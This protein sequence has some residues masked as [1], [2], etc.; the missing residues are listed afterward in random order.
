MVVV[1]RAL[2]GVRSSAWSSM[3]GRRHAEVLMRFKASA[4][5]IAARVVQTRATPARRSTVTFRA[6]GV[7]R[8]QHR[9]TNVMRFGG[10]L[11]VAVA[12]LTLSASAC[13]EGVGSSTNSSSGG[14]P[15]AAGAASLP[16][17]SGFAARD[18]AELFTWDHV[19]TFEATL[20]NERW[21]Y[22]RAHA[23]DEAYEP[24][25]VRFEGKSLGTVGLRFKGS[26]GTLRTC[27]DASGQLKCAKLSMKLGFDEYRAE[28]RFFGLKRLNLHAMMHDDSKLHER[29]GYDL[30][31]AMGIYAPR[32]SW[33]I[34]KVNGESLGLFS[35]VEQIDGR[36]AADRFPDAGD[37]N[38]YKEAWPI[39]AEAAYYQAH[40]ETEPIDER[41]SAHSAATELATS[42]ATATE[43]AEQLAVLSPS[44]DFDYLARYMAVDDAIVNVDGVTATY[45]GTDPRFYQNH[46]FY[47]YLEEQRPKFWLI[48][49]DL[50]ATFVPRGDFE[51]VPRWNSA[52]PDCSQL[53]WVWG[54]VNVVSP[55]CDPVFRALASSPDQYRMAVK[56]LLAG[57]FDEVNLRAEIE[58]HVA[59][60]QQAVADDLTGPGS[61]SWRASIAA[62]EQRIPVLRKRLEKAMDGL[63]V[64]PFSLSFDE[65]NDFESAEAAS[66]ESGV[67]PL[68]NSST[69]IGVS[70]N[71]AAPIRGQRDLRFDFT[72]RNEGAPP[73]N[74]WGQWT[75]FPV[76]LDE[77]PRDVSEL[78]GLRLWLRA[79]SPRALRVDLDSGEY[80]AADEGIKF[81]W[82]VNV[83]PEASQVELRF[84]D[85]KLPAWAHATADVLSRVLAR[86]ENVA[87][88]AACAGRDAEG[89]LPLGASDTGYL[90]VDE[91]E[92]F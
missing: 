9:F 5:E 46:N 50:D 58:R 20:P 4:H 44:L 83:G 34:L 56:D 42:L 88:Q 2:F 38:L 23:I 18:A 45:T 62:L 41:A 73:Q 68:A 37:G 92:F 39:H 78:S 54:G 47:L 8:R 3:A 52:S 24:A 33:A 84:S 13:G 49:W 17:S 66:I 87:F 32:S 75:Y 12:S 76:H 80:E 77:S 55:A 81:G 7:R 51:R 57:A 27:V 43:P 31:R 11:F 65:L 72:Y 21:S 29:L 89:F 16:D 90:E 15:G 22:L 79:D 1:E 10:R 69:S 25:E 28:T 71:E 82:E 36:F 59:F 60:I 35:M 70:L 85:A 48:P 14:S 40:L 74:P 19:P 86:V 53:Y 26:V 91:L 63:S 61:S 6:I 64:P 30:F 67:S